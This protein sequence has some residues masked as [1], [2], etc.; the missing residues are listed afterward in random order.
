MTIPM[1]YVQVIEP[2]MN[3]LFDVYAAT[4]EEFSLIFPNQPE[5]DVEFAEDLYHRLGDDQA[6]S[7]LERLWVRRQD[8]RLVPG[9]Q[10]TLFF[11]YPERRE[12][13][14]GKSFRTA[15]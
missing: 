13:F 4:E 1:R 5:Q 7:L 2:A 8:K 12:L 6:K 11:Q 14:P 15:K 10:G 9:I 3:C